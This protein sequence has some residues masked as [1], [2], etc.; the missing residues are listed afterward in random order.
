MKKNITFR[1]VLLGTIFSAVFAVVSIRA[2]HL[3]NIYLSASQM[4]EASL[5]LL[6]LMVLL[7][8]PICRLIRFIRPFSAIEMM[9]IFIM[10][11]VS[12][13]ISSF[14]LA[15]PLAAH[16]SG[17]FYRQWNNRQSEWAEYVA[18]F[19]NEAYFLSEPGIREKAIEHHK[20]FTV[21]FD[22]QTTYNM[23][24]RLERLAEELAEAQSK[25]DRINQAPEG[26]EQKIRLNAARLELDNAKHAHARILDQWEERTAEYGLP[27]LDEVLASYPALI[28]ESN[29]HTE[30][31]RLE[32]DKVQELAFE[33][34]D[35]FRQGLPTEKR[36]YP[37]VLMLAE[38][39]ISTYRSRL[40]RLVNGLNA[41]KSIQQAEEYL[42]TL[43]ADSVTGQQDAQILAGFIDA[44]AADLAK[45]SDDSVFENRRQRAWEKRESLDRR[46]FEVRSEISELGAAK[47]ESRDRALT[48][49]IDS[50]IHS[51]HN[52]ISNLQRQYKRINSEREVV[53]RE[54]A[55]YERINNM[56][57]VLN[58]ISSDLRENP[59][60]VAELNKQINN[61]IPDFPAID[62][63]LRRF[64][65]GQIPWRH[66][67]RPLFNWGVLIA[68][69]YI[70]LMTF[71]VLIFRQWA[72]NEK[73]TYPLME[74][75]KS[76]LGGLHD[77]KE[78][79]LPPIFKNPLFWI[80]VVIPVIV[81][82]WNLICSMNLAPGLAKIDLQ[83]K[84]FTYLSGT[85]L[86]AWRVSR[87][88]V[89]FT[90]I[91]L[92]FLIP[93]NISFSL[94]FFH[95]AY[96]FI[97]LFMVLGG[98][99]YDESSFPANWWH[100]MNFRNAIG[101]GALV[102]F[103]GLVL[104]KC[105]QYL[106]CC[107]NGASVSGLE[108]GERKELRI[109]SFLFLASSLGLIA[110]LW[111][112]M[113]ANL[114]HTVFMYFFVI[115]I[116]IGLVRVVC[117]GGLSG[118]KTFISPFHFVRNLFGLNL[119][120][121]SASLFTPLIVYYA[122]LFADVKSFI[123]PAMANSLKLRDDFKMKRG[124]FHIAVALAIIVASVASVMV[125]VMMGY[126]IGADRLNGWFASAFP[127]STFD[128]VKTMVKDAPDVSSSA[129]MWMGIGAGGMALLL[130]ARQFVFW[131]PHPLG[132]IMFINPAMG[133]YW[134]SIMI[135]WLANVLIT[136]YAHKE[137]YHKATGFFIGLI[138]GELIMVA[139]SSVIALSMGVNP[140]IDLNRN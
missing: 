82:G 111:L 106:L 133:A 13:G 95:L 51:L 38:D 138:I 119:A 113:G 136:K 21:S 94:W 43:P 35:E 65:V 91:G 62:A 130:F 9:I 64:F 18:P 12:A 58:G 100:I 123:A 140:G 25:F 68:L 56:L 2:T 128:T 3:N 66:W 53:S 125:W 87:S 42:K 75:P 50:K 72:H 7:I 93:K 89:F 46:I 57:G 88:E 39:D 37:G 1:S 45:V 44:A 103:S 34:A 22:L 116:T 4:P 23:A 114:L 8:N 115:I 92:A 135:G 86:Q 110:I 137:T 15:H 98:H 126:D 20:A 27:E 49:Q 33:K 84:W 74:I 52:E 11:M 67:A 54:L 47:R 40:Q 31:A 131:L 81:L 41:L 59:V 55:I 99:G 19:V 129:R 117:E 139:L 96:M 70:L 71:N 10:G 5:V 80:G 107:F 32:L 79:A 134:F 36:A 69:S 132:L 26:P 109:S 76:L 108:S 122:V 29:K 124:H 6:L 121:T 77:G 61:I 127:K 73:L 60:P 104:Y 112:G 102:V 24:L 97:V 83:N 14:G 85:N 105:K 78:D 30:Q 118:L 16:V 28:E 48:R 90:A 101:G 120:W 63:S 17:L